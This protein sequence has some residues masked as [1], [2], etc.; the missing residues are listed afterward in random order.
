MD[1]WR[2]LT[3]LPRKVF[4]MRPTAKSYTPAEVDQITRKIKGE[5]PLLRCVTQSI[6]LGDNNDDPVG[7]SSRD[8]SELKPRLAPVTRIIPRKKTLRSR[9]VVSLQKLAAKWYWK[10]VLLEIVPHI[11]RDSAT[12]TVRQKRQ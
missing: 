5:L 11:L 6:Q 7:L 10:Q 9:S 2:F 4:K 12:Q 3:G 1:T 8:R